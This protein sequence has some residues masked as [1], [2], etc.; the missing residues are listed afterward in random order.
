MLKKIEYN[1]FDA[2]LKDL[3]LFFSSV[4]CVL[5]LST[6]TLANE[7]DIKEI[8]TEGRAVIIDGDKKLAKK[9]ALDD[10]LY[11]ASLRGGAKVDGYSNVDSF[12]RL[13]ENLLVRPAST[14][15][16]FVIIDESADQTHY[17]VKIKAYLVNINSTSSCNERPYVNVSYLSPHFTVSSRLDPWTHKLPKAISHNIKQSLK[18]IDFIK[19]KDRSNVL[20]NPKS[21]AIKSSDLDYDNIVEGK[22]V[23]V[24]D[25][26]FAVH[27]TILIDSI[28]GKIGRFSKELLVNLTLDIYENRNFQLINSL[29]YQFSLLLGQQTGYQHIDAFY[30]QPYDKIKVLVDKSLSKVQ[31]RIM[32]QLKCQPLQAF[33]RKVDNKIIVSLG[34]NQGLKKGKVGIVSTNGNDDMNMNDWIVVTVKTINDDFSEIEPLNPSNKIDAIEGKFIKFLK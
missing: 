32:D 10:A 31:Y 21:I 16:D 20:F 14:I 3:V 7:Y 25:G 5:L 9:R 11:I 6:Y 15:T 33:A 12:T 23:S 17:S 26:E 28:N 30:K 18:K 8:V 27:P 1:T 2:V 29:E 4:L 22:T 19:L 13:N 34:A 24:K